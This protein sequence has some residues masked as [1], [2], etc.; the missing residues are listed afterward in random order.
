MPP[1]L[2]FITTCKGRRQHLAETLPKLA[3]QADTETIVVDYDCPDGTAEWVQENFP[4]VK[5]VRVEN[6]P[7]FNIA[8]A[9]NLGAGQATSPWLFFV[10]ADV[11]VHSGFSTAV[12]P[13][14]DP[15][16]YFQCIHDRKALVGS[17][18][19]PQRVF[20]AIGG[21][22]DVFEGW[23]GED[24]DLSRRIE[25]SGLSPVELPA[26]LLDT[27][28]HN[29]ELRTRFY[30]NQD[31]ETGWLINQMYLRIKHDMMSLERTELPRAVR[32]KLYAGVRQE[33]SAAR[34]EQ[35][36]VSLTLSAGWQPFVADRE[37]EQ[38]LTVRVRRRRS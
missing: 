29:T 10:D 11:Q 9:R 18:L 4:A 35:R 8:R 2:S 12:L 37:I 15:T 7:V 26:Y 6:A 21:Y 23:G 19:L 34:A 22:D 32:A 27:I 36:E 3:Q 33:I 25:W 38:S 30:Q 14:L 13:M 28:H 16:H 24:V 31:I 5:L 17:I 1:A 20:T